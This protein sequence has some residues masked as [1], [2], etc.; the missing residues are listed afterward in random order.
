[1]TSTA[2]RVDLVSSVD[3]RLRKVA[4]VIRRSMLDAMP[5]GEPSRWLYAPMRE[6]PS[7]PGK[8][9]RPALCL[10]AGRAFGGD[11]E[12]L[13]GVALAVRF[14]GPSR[15]DLAAFLSMLRPAR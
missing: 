6:Y 5:D 1:M 10:A 14:Q 9:L 2:D 4:Q 13:L 11:T 8:A 7:R 3:E 12:D 15:G